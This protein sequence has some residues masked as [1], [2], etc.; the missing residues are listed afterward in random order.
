[1]KRIPK[2]VFESLVSS[3]VITP[4]D[5]RRLEQAGA[6]ADGTRTAGS[7]RD[8]I[9][10]AGGDPELVNM[11]YSCREKLNAQIKESGLIIGIWVKHPN[12]D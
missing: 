10:N 7:V 6:V 3:G 8:Q 12:P 2:A 4:D 1:M 5:A 11:M 9:I